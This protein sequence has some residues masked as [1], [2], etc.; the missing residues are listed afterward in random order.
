MRTSRIAAAGAAAAAFAATAWTAPGAGAA[1]SPA[2][3]SA[4]PVPV[5]QVAASAEQAVLDLS[6]AARL[7]SGQS[8]SPTSA[9]R[10]STGATHTRMDR[11]YRGLAVRG[12]D[13]VVHQ[14][15]DGRPLGVSQTLSAPLTLSTTPAVS[16]AAA[17]RTVRSVIGRYGA[18]AQGTTPTLVVDA[19]SGP[20]D[21]RGRS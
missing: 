8:T 18:V 20:P 15:A 1:S 19:V 7:G 11:T 12:G 2:P 21:S 10:D 5:G 9:L 6:T 13:L 3:L 16:A 17:V 14:A 4:R